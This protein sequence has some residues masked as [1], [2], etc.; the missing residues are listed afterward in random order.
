[1]AHIIGYEEIHFDD[2][3]NFHMDGRGVHL[4]KVAVHEVGHVLGLGHSSTPSSVMYPIYSNPPSSFFELGPEDRQAVQRIYGVC[5]GSFDVVFDWLYRI[6]ESETNQIKYGYRTFFVRNN[7]FWVYENRNNR[8]RYGDP[9]P[10][11]TQWAG[12]PSN[13]KGLIQYEED[14]G[15][16]SVI[17]TYFFSG[18]RRR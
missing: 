2:D 3:E 10:I 7:I 12:L 14:S 13:L 16:S 18:E 11:A 4:V 5:K 17:Y 8:A 1:M 9:S 6:W 15:S